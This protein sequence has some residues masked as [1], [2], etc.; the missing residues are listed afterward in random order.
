MA[1]FRL[2]DFRPLMIV[3]TGTMHG[4]DM[5][6]LS[7]AAFEQRA[8]YCKNLFRI[9]CRLISSSLS[10][11]MDH[12][13]AKLETDSNILFKDRKRRYLV[14]KTKYRRFFLSHSCTA[15]TLCR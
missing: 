2:I 4:L 5:E 6:L 7:A 8:L 14:V 15:A 12:Q 13:Q 9:L 3:T 10:H 1:K 11:A